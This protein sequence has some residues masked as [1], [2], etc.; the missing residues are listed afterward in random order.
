MKT[1]AYGRVPKTK[2]AIPAYLVVLAEKLTPRFER[3][4]I[5]HKLERLD[6]NSGRDYAWA[7]RGGRRRRHQGPDG[8]VLQYLAVDWRSVLFLHL[9]LLSAC[10]CAVAP[11]GGADGPRPAAAPFARRLRLPGRRIASRNAPGC[12]LDGRMRDRFSGGCAFH[13]STAG[14]A[15]SERVF[16]CRRC[17]H[18]GG[19]A[20]DLPQAGSGRSAAP[21]TEGEADRGLARQCALLRGRTDCPAEQSGRGAGQS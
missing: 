19:M 15:Y 9:D 1:L 16:R 5:R 10:R 3:E 13:G 11:I 21:R 6:C 12:R 2:K 18:G 8:G 17:G 20:N 7:G 14:A 4:G